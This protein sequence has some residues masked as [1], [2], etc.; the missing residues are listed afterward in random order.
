MK[1]RDMALCVAAAWCAV[2]LAGA[3]AQPKKTAPAAAAQKAPPPPRPRS[4]MT[5]NLPE[6]DE[7]KMPKALYV[8]PPV[9]KS[10]QPRRTAW[11]DPD[12]R[13]VWPTDSLGGLPL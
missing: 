10:F 6:V 1:T 4:S 9:P 5:S 13:G 7:S 8:L 3:D 12:L 11:G 2:G